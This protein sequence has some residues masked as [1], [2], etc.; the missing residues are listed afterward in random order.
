ML[1]A[2]ASALGLAGLPHCAAMCAAPCSAAC[3][4]ASADFRARAVVFQVARL[5]GY[6]VAGA[7]VAGSVGALAQLSAWS[8]ALRPVWALFHALVLALG[9]WFV[10]QGR[11]PA[12]MGSL[13]RAP[14][15][16]SA[17]A[18]P[19]GWQRMQGPAR[20]AAAGMVWVAWPCGLLQSALLVASLANTAA[21]GALAMAGFALASSAGLVAGPWLW[22]RLRGGGRAGWSE[23]IL[24]RVS[25]ALL[26][27]GSGFALGQGVWHQVAAYC[28]WT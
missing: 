17:S 16:A 27:L 9:L 26:V 19:Q 22:A 21:G 10:W 4:G 23:S 5:A 18:P 8:P 15:P 1:I 11:Q 14:A 3:G 7:V 2:S 6:A 13:G 24:I 20:A 25:G 28:G 12:W